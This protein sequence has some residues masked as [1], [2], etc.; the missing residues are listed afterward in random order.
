MKHRVTPTDRRRSALGRIWHVIFAATASAALMMTCLPGLP[1]YA[2]DASQSDA[3]T[4]GNT[5]QVGDTQSQGE[6]DNGNVITDIL[7]V[8]TATSTI[9]DTSGYHMSVTVSNTTDE[10]INNA[11]LTVSANASYLFVSRTDIQQWA[12]GTARIPTPST[13]GQAAIAS[14][15]PG[16]TTTVSIDVAADARIMQSFT[17]WGPKPVLVSLSDDAGHIDAIHTFVTRSPADLNNAQTPALN[18]TMAMPL[19]GDSWSVNT[20]A[21][22]DQIAGDNASDVISPNKDAAA[23]H[24]TLEQTIAKHDDLQIVGD[25]TYLTTLTMPTQTDGIMQPANFDITNYS[26]YDNRDAFNNAGIS[27]QDWNAETAVD[28]LR[29][30][31]GDAQAQSNVYAWQGDANW[32]LD[33]L[34]VAAEQGYSTVIATH[35]FDT[36]DSATVETGK[37]VVPTDSGDITVLAAQNVLTALAQSQPTSAQ[38]DGETTDAGRL[39]RFVAQSAFYQMEQPYASR[40]L[41]VCMDQDV[42][43]AFADALMQAIEQSSWLNTTDLQTL[44]AADACM[45]GE[46]ALQAVPTESGLKAQ[47]KTSIDTVLQQSQRTNTTIARFRNAIIDGE[48]TAASNTASTIKEWASGLSNTATNLTLAALE[49][50]DD[51]QGA[52]LEAIRNIRS[53]LGDTVRITPSE[54]VSVVSETANMP[55]TVSNDLPFAISIQVASIT[56][57]AQIVTSRHEDIRIPANSEAQVTFNI[58]VITSGRATATTTLLDRNGNVF[59]LSQTT[60]IT[61]ALQINDKSGFV[62][63][64]FAVL[65]G[66][67]GLWRQFN[68]TKDPDE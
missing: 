49:A 35:D 39:S 57:S 19:T 55:V 40:N 64:A 53:D 37:Y 28:D 29:D 34:N 32:T 36:D 9:T 48:S 61:S 46:D 13:L 67:V 26:A 47:H 42:D 33:A 7:R 38:A 6:A 58:R 3:N 56:D 21:V 16:Q 10:I 68:R 44:A 23:K 43:P 15:N 20:D 2:E 4:D 60:T 30:A 25:P 66:I 5:S 1:A 52:L 31:L 8:D 22:D 18:I 14:L 50:D 17:T 65:L 54:T 51:S 63:I 59:G 62:I 41:L 27:E 11:T 24:K 12:E 45:V